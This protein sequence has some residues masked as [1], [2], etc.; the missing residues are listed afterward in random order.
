V[1]RTIRIIAVLVAGLT[2]GACTFVPTDAQPQVVPSH[3][4]PFNLLKPAPLTKGGST[5]L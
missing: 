3:S 2:L 5:E 1:K 4:V